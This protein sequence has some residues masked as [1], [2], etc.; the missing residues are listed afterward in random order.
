MQCELM[1]K[2]EK[3]KRVNPRHIMSAVVQAGIV[4]LHV[5]RG[6]T[7]RNKE[8]AFLDSKIIEGKLLT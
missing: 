1:M 4:P 7:D 2:N 6:F 5:V 3:K 8:L